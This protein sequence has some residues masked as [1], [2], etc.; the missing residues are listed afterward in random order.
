MFLLVCRGHTVWYLDTG[1]EFP[2]TDSAC[3]EGLEV[4]VVALQELL[5]G[6]RL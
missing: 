5:D 2:M 1:N 6:T 4:L 3:D